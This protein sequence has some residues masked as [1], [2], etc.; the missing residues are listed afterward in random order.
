MCIIDADSA[1]GLYFHHPTLSMCVFVC[2]PKLVATH[3]ITHCLSLNAVAYRGHEAEPFVW[4][5][6]GRQRWH[7]TARDPQGEKADTHNLFP[8]HSIPKLVPG[9]NPDYTS[10]SGGGVR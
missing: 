1:M 10:E 4:V 9:I 5:T 7:G 3:T 2:V 6:G 8:L